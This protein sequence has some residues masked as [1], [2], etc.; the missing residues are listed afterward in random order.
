MLG[1]LGLG[2]VRGPARRLPYGLFV[3]GLDVLHEW[4]KARP[5]K[6]LRLHR[7]F[8]HARL[9]VTNSQATRQMLQRL[10]LLSVPSVVIYPGVDPRVFRPLDT[11]PEELRRVLGLPT[12]G[13]LVLFLGRPVRRKGLHLLLQVLPHLPREIHLVVAGAG[14][15]SAYRQQARAL[16]LGNRVSFLGPVPEERLVPLYNAT[17]LLAMPVVSQ[18]HDMEGFGIV[19]LEANAC[20]RPVLGSRSGGV[21]EAVAHGKTGWLVPP[22]DPQALQEALL[23]L[24]QDPDLRTRLGRAGR[25][26]VL[27]SFTWDLQARRLRDAYRQY[28]CPEPPAAA[29]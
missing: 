18:P 10:N 25:E 9:V 11:P 12:S 27:R 4:K 2:K 8:R 19:Y 24:Y 5:W 1:H 21:P 20:E 22:D 28:L 7:L 13:F 17:D 6:H 26:R 16:G 15:F 14:D 23:K 3:H 29:K